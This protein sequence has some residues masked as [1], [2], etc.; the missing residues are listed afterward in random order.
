MQSERAAGDG[1]VDLAVEVGLLEPGRAQGLRGDADPRAHHRIT[2]AELTA[3][4][5]ESVNLAAALG[6]QVGVVG[7]S[8][9]AVLAAWLAG[10]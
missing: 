5:A 3:Y 9:G 2:A 8:G 4:A 7:I 1:A 10:A 6:D